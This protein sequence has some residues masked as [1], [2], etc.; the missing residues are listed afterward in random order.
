MGALADRIS[1]RRAL[2]LNLVVCTCGMASLILARQGPM[3]A[4]FVVLYG[5]SV[6][7]P[8]TLM[9][10]VMVESLGLRRFGSL[11]GLAGVFNV[12]GAAAGPVTA[13]RIFDLTG[14]YGPAFELYVLALA[15]GAAATAGCVPLRA[16]EARPLVRRRKKTAHGR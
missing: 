14:R 8:L 16:A 6:G 4:A 5:I 2:V 10:L 1:A 7:A 11:S 9:P 13:G 15:V 3:A 12:L